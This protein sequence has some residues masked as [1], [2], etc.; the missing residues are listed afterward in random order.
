MKGGAE[1]EVVLADITAVGIRVVEVVPGVV[2]TQRG[3]EGEAAKVVFGTGVERELVGAVGVGVAAQGVDG[4]IVGSEGIL[5]LRS[6]VG[7]DAKVHLA[8]LVVGQCKVGGDAVPLGWSKDGEATVE[9]EGGEAVVAAQVA[10]ER[11]AA[12]EGAGVVHEEHTA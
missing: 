5:P 11:A 8:M 6:K 3:S 4:V 2:A 9:V 12:G 7:H 10:A 1:G